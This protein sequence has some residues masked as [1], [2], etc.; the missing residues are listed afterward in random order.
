MS[1]MVALGSISSSS[2]GACILQSRQDFIQCCQMVCG[3]LPSHQYIICVTN[4]TRH[5]TEKALHHSLKDSRSRG[6]SKR[7][8]I[9]TK[10]ALM[11]IDHHIGFGLPIKQD[12]LECVTH[13]QL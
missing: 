5:P 8:V 4:N 1:Q 9:V 13:I 12:L 2:N 7:Q 10:K 3:G 6:N 11:G